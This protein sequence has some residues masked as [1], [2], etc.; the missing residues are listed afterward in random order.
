MQYAVNRAVVNDEALKTNARNAVLRDLEAAYEEAVD[1]MQG[2]KKLTINNAFLIPTVLNALYK[3]ARESGDASDIVRR[4]RYDRLQ[5]IFGSELSAA[6]RSR[7][8]P[9]QTEAEKRENW[10][11]KLLEGVTDED[12]QALEEGLGYDTSKDTPREGGLLLKLRQSNLSLTK[13]VD[14]L[15]LSLNQMAT[16]LV[17]LEKKQLKTAEQLE[18]LEVLL[19]LVL[20]QEMEPKGELE[21]VRA[22]VAVQVKGLK[23]KELVKV[24]G[25]KLIMLKYRK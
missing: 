18:E 5:Q 2:R 15:I 17:S 1:I 9:I 21:L 11:R 7:R 6:M 22:V 10:I 8:D 13:R 3:K 24:R 25:R 12:Q 14:L 19:E 16:L 20:A 23:E 4:E